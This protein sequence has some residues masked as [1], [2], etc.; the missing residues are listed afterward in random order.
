MCSKLNRHAQMMVAERGMSNSDEEINPHFDRKDF[1]TTRVVLHLSHLLMISPK[2]NIFA[3]LIFS[4]IS[5]LE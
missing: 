3:I 1:S 2:P 5:V 4:T